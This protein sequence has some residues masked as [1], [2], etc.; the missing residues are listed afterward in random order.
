MEILSDFSTSVRRALE[1]IDPQYESYDGLV[2]CGSHNPRLEE[3][4]FLISKIQ[5]ARETKRP[6]L[7][8]CYGHQ[9]AAVEYARN[10]LGI[11]DA[12]SEEFG[13]PGTFIVKKRASGLQV[14]LHEGDSYW[15]NYCVDPEFY[16]KW[17]TLDHFITC[18][19]HPEYESSVNNHHPLLAKFIELCKK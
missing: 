15:N 14:G 12:T 17:P 1:E 9:L 6:F 8:I 3:V 16:Q 18:Q 19:F 7:G 5:E 10:V 11:K 4:D 2:I 13:V